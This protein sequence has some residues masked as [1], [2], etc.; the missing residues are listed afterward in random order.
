M[1]KQLSTNAALKNFDFLDAY[2]G[3]AVLSVVCAH[4]NYYTT[5]IDAYFGTAFGVV[6]FFQ[7]SA[8]IL[9]YRLLVQYEKAPSLFH[10]TLKYMVMRFCRI[11]LTYLA[12]CAIHW[13]YLAVTN[14]S[15]YDVFHMV[16]LRVEKLSLGH[17]WTLPIEVGVL[18]S[19]LDDSNIC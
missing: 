11:Y 10:V 16:T 5:K 2:R 15:R 9:T 12:F 8:F 3:L 7:L 18:C 19:Y 17:L 4:T 1:S 13:V 6:A 14:G